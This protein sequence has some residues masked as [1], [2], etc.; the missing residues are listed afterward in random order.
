MG[1]LH[2]QSQ[3]PPA[4]RCSDRTCEWLRRTFITLLL[5]PFHLPLQLSTNPTLPLINRYSSGNKTTLASGPSTATSPGT[6]RADFMPT[7]WSGRPTFK[8]RSFH[9]RRIR[10]VEIGP[11]FRAGSCCRRLIRGC[12]GVEQWHGWE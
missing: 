5:C 7:S 8:N 1:R 10:I 12:N 9:R 2:H 6:S 3:Q 11:I 4:S